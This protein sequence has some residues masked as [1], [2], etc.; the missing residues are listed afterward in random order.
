LPDELGKDK[1]LVFIP[2]SLQT[3]GMLVIVPKADLI[4]VDIP[5]ETLMKLELTA[6]TA[7]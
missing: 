6:G 4:P 3:S 1:V 7:F 2:I 5:V